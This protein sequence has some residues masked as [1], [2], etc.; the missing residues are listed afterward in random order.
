MGKTTSKTEVSLDEL[1]P[2]IR[3]RIA[4]GQ[5]VRFYPNGVSMLPMLRPRVD[6]VVLSAPPPKLKKHDLALYQREGGAFVLHRII[7]V[8]ETYCC[9]GDNQFRQET[10]LKHEQI[11]ALVTAFYRGDKLHS[12]H[13][14][15]YRLYCRFWRFYRKVRIL[16]LR[17]IRRLRIKDKT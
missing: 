13:E 5:S 6:S 16:R 10:G 8:G 9:V 11:I 3:E 17:L 12:V 2:L 4:Q 15:G 1:M 7:E 14:P